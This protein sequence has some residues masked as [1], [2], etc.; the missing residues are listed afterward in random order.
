M[1]EEGEVVARGRGGQ[2]HRAVI[3]I[4]VDEQQTVALGIEDRAALHPS[5]GVRRV[6]VAVEAARLDRHRV[7]HAVVAV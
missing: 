1:V 4:T 7:H 6:E 3:A 5:L 2:R